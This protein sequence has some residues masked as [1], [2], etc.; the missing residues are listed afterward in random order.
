VPDEELIWVEAGKGR[1]A[2]GLEGES[3][4][5]NWETEIEERSGENSNNRTGYG[6]KNP[7]R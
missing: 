2:R 5:G 1:L 7:R 3:S 6:R 4:V